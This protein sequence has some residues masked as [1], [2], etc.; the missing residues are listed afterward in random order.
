[1][2]PQ[3]FIIEVEQPI[4]KKDGY[5]YYAVLEAKR[6]VAVLESYLEQRGV[7]LPDGYSTIDPNYF[8]PEVI[9]YEQWAELKPEKRAYLAGL[10]VFY[11]PIRKK[12]KN[13]FNKILVSF[14]ARLQCGIAPLK[15]QVL[16]APRD[17]KSEGNAGL[18]FFELTVRSSTEVLFQLQDT[19]KVQK[20]KL[21]STMSMPLSP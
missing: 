20:I 21:S 2:K 5:L 12:C 9:A 11:V 7:T 4:E 3:K 15:P 6:Q 18:V 17:Y 1:M 19:A 13:L 10:R 8:P 16:Y 14:S